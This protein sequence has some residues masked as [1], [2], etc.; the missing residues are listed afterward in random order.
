MFF[1]LTKIVHLLCLMFVVR[2]VISNIPGVLTIMET[3]TV[4]IALPLPG[5]ILSPNYTVGSIGGRMMKAAAI[6]KYRHLACEAV[7]AER[8][9]SLPWGIVSVTASFFYKT[10]RRRDQDN[11][12]A[13][14]KAA[15]D[16]I[17]DAGVVMDDDYEHMRRDVPTFSYDKEY[18]RVTL[19]ITRIK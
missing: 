1:S 5:G 13:S 10:K 14:L 3:E 18:P 2:N 8:I 11:A 4:V 17:V 16:G 15:H 9:E 19:T 6:K 12:M 7:E